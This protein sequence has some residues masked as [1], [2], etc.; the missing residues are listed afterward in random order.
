MDRYDYLQRLWHDFNVI[1]ASGFM[2]TV[3]GVFWSSLRIPAP[4]EV[5]SL[6]RKEVLPDL[7]G[8]LFGLRVRY[9]PPNV[10]DS[11]DETS[12]SATVVHSVVNKS[13]LVMGGSTEEQPWRR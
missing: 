11:E 4:G 3:D 2:P 10:V 9:L 7:N 13:E 1:A 8:F 12:S 5:F 6:S